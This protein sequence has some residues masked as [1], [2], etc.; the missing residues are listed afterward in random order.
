M[1]ARRRYLIAWTFFAL[2]PTLGACVRPYVPAPRPVVQLTRAGDAEL[3]LSSGFAGAA[4]HAAYALGD[5]WGVRAAAAYNPSPGDT[6]VRVEGGVVRFGGRALAMPRLE[7]GRLFWTL[8]LDVGGGRELA[9]PRVQL[10]ADAEGAL[11][12]RWRHGSLA[13]AL[14]TTYVTL[15][16]RATPLATARDGRALNVEPF[17]E[18][19]A[20]PS[21]LQVFVQGG[22]S[23]PLFKRGDMGAAWPVLLGAGISYVSGQHSDE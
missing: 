15:R 10:G 19:R 20:G 2:P 9:A 12:L 14:G 8:A 13:M 17:V 4:A 16:Q 18:L 6:M 7:G 5:R 21:W 22:L 23:Y 1:Y 3:A 11:G